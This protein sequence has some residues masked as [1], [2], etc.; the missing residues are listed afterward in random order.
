MHAKTINIIVAVISIMSLGC[1]ATQGDVSSVYARQTRLEAK[2]DRLSNQVQTISQK[3]TT[4]TGTDVELREK[5]SLK[6]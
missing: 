1:V 2:M 3:E 4:A 5:L 6:L